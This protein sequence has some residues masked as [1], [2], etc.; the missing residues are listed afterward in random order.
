MYGYSINFENNKNNNITS[1]LFLKINLTTWYSVIST[2]ILYL[3]R[4][5]IG[6]VRQ[7]KIHFNSNSICFGT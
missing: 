3:N 7:I 5:K 1:V 4:G 6:K 2:R